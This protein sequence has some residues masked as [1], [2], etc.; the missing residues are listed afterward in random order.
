MVRF[1]INQLKKI[2]S[3]KAGKPIA[4][5]TM[6]SHAASFA[7]YRG[8]CAARRTRNSPDQNSVTRVV[9]LSSDLS[10]RQFDGIASKVASKR[11]MAGLR[12]KTETINPNAHTPLVI[13]PGRKK[14]LALSEPLPP[15]VAR[16]AANA[17]P[18]TE[19]MA[20]I[21]GFFRTI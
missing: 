4:D 10:D 20:F 7:K 13:N 6:P 18:I 21:T 9:M 5:F 16:K 14:F 11:P 8:N 12:T 17:M 19:A 3:A 1:S 15:L 2:Q